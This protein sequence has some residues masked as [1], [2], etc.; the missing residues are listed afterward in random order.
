VGKGAVTGRLVAI[1]REL[2]EVRR[3]LIAIRTSLI[4]I[5]IRLFATRARLDQIRECL[6]VFGVSL[7]GDHPIPFPGHAAS[8]SDRGASKVE[9][10]Q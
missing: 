10:M 8:R 2:I 7:A 9:V 1:G 6:I 3:A 4:A 5:G